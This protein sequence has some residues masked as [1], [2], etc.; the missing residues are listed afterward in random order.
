MRTKNNFKDLLIYIMINIFILGIIYYFYVSDIRI[1]LIYNLFGIPC[2]GCGLT[3]SLIYLLRGDLLKSLQYNV[4]TIPLIIIYV[5]INLWYII[6]IVRDTTS[7][8]D[9]I[10]VNKKKL[11]IICIIVFV[12]IS[13]RNITNPLLY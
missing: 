11:I 6:D 5:I 10:N 2:A 8:K 4:I 12:L 3:N 1:C 13:L 9:T 7:L